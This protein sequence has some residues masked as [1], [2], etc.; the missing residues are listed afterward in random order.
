MRMMAV[1][2]KG[3]RLRHIGHLDIQRAMQRALRRSGLPV[4]YSNGFNPHILVSFASALQTGASGAREV[5]DVTLDKAVAPE[6][7]VRAMND[8]LPRDMRLSCARAM[9]DKHPALMSLLAAADYEIR[10]LDA[11]SAEKMLAAIDGFLSQE[12]IPT[13]R[14]TK[15]GVKEC[16][17]KPLILALRGS[18]DTLYARLVLNEKEACKTD[19]LVTAL[20]AFAGVQMPRVLVRRAALL[21]HDAEGRLVPLE[22]L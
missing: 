3:E 20:S 10:V 4:S 8:A 21:G 1:F 5:M 13:L 19:M 22:T 15:S 16:D 12:T 2:E 14:K 11:E 17:A 6:D 7:F 9:E 18:G